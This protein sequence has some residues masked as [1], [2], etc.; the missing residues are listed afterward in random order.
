MERPLVSEFEHSKVVHIARIV[1][2]LK[3]CRVGG[4]QETLQNQE[5]EN[6]VATCAQRVHGA[7]SRR[8]KSLRV[9]LVYL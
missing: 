5:A 7:L 1:P 6:L 8:T 9:H 2:L 3:G 4:F